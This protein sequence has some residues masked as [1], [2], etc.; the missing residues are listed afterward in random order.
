MNKD[1]LVGKTI[2]FCLVGGWELSGEVKSLDEDKFIVE[3]NEA[4][5]MVFKNK[6]SGLIVSKD[7]RVLRPPEFNNNSYERSPVTKKAESALGRNF[8]MNGIAY[9][10]SG[11]SI[12]RGLLDKEFEDEGDDLSMFFPGGHSLPDDI[13]KPDDRIEFEI[14][15]DS[16][17]KD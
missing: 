12:P 4:L 1:N 5:I 9:E 2:T 15:D 16:T 14:E 7:A 6:I 13:G 3:N 8:P 11:M 10:E 17:D